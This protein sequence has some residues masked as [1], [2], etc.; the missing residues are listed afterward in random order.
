MRG[1]VLK[2]MT[3]GVIL[4]FAAGSYAGQQPRA[5]E[6]KAIKTVLARFY[7]GWNA[8]DPDAMVSIY[9]EDID[10]INVWGEWNKGKEAIRKDLAAIHS[11]SARNSQRNFTIEK[12]RFLTPEVAVVQVSTVQVSSSSSAGP[13]LG[14]YVL[15]K[16]NGR[17]LAV[18][19]TNV[20][21][22]TPPYKR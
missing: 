16:Q 2:P 5:E 17:W 21:P 12:I 14:T 19:F 15:Q 1:D 10:H 11:A 20:A 18:S 7:D 13:T 4:I 6:E 9:A 8:H 3:L 22:Q